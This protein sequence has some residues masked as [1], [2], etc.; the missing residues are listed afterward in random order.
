M[1]KLKR[2]PENQFW[3]VIGVLKR[4]NFHKN[5]VTYWQAIIKEKLI[6]YFNYKHDECLINT[7]MLN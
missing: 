7:T 1:Y 3:R 4:I 2:G 5:N 6:K